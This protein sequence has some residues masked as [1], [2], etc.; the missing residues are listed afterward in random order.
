MRGAM[1]PGFNGGLIGPWPKES[2]ER[3]P[4]DFALTGTD[5]SEKRAKLLGHYQQ[6]VRREKRD[7]YPKIGSQIL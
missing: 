3:A 7:D 2:V 6:L 5:V 1:D 4:T